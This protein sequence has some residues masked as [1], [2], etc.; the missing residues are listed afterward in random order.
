[1]KT[2]N[3][4]GPGRPAYEVKWPA[5]KFT[6]TQLMERNGVNPKSGKG[7]NCT[8]LTLYKHLKAA[9][10]GSKSEIVRIKDETRKPNSKTGMGRKAFVY[11]RR[12]K[13]NG[14]K[15]MTKN[16]SVKNAKPKTA[17]NKPVD[18][19]EAMKATLLTSSD[20]Q[21]KVPETVPVTVEQSQEIA[22]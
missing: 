17:T 21:S 22:V 12:E 15:T 7:N 2:K 3:A 9:S 11:I 4:T 10:K 16:T 6:F 18:S 14:M 1:M 13:F 5:G 19:Y 20:T 8:R